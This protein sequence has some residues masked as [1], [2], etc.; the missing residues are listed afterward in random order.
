VSALQWYW[1]DSQIIA[2]GIMSLNSFI[3]IDLQKE[4]INTYLGVFAKQF[5]IGI[6]DDDHGRYLSSDV[7]PP[8]IYYYLS[9]DGNPDNGIL[10]YLLDEHGRF[11]N[12]R[13]CGSY[14]VP[15]S[16]SWSDSTLPWYLKARDHEVSLSDPKGLWK[17]Q[18]I[19]FVYLF[20]FYRDKYHW[21]MK[22]RS[23]NH[24][25]QEIHMQREREKLLT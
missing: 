19:F 21:L 22:Y 10:I 6:D 11:E 20:D 14:K 9:S 25:E 8:L 24:I 5:E 7:S 23:H 15:V 2:E 12:G 13:R 1:Q 16:I 3:E 18:S 4:I 17:F